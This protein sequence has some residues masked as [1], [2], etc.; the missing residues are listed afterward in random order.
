MQLNRI[1][2]H[3]RL[4]FFFFPPLPS[5]SIDST[6]PLQTNMEKKNFQVIQRYISS[7]TFSGKQKAVTLFHNLFKLSFKKLDLF[8]SLNTAIIFL[9]QYLKFKIAMSSII[10]YRSL[11]CVLLFSYAQPQNEGQRKMLL[12]GLIKILTEHSLVLISLGF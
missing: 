12:K 6:L 4:L 8:I 11:S 1:Y 5:T 9:S 7:L 2:F 3:I 10:H